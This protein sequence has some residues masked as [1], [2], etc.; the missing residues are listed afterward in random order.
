MNASAK[1]ATTPEVSAACTA[2]CSE[3]IP[4]KPVLGM[5]PS[6]AHGQPWHCYVPRKE[7]PK[8]GQT[9]EGGWEQQSPS[10]LTLVFRVFHLCVGPHRECPAN[11]LREV[12]QVSQQ[13]TAEGRGLPGDPYQFWGWCPLNLKEPFQCGRPEGEF[14]V[15]IRTSIHFRSRTR[16]AQA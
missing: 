5:A 2:N 9:R 11:S 1:D 4:E 10:R 13:L 16:G 8:G 15:C 12:S 6:V 14:H 7:N 3:G